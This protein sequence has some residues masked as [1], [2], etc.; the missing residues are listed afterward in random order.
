MAGPA[1]RLGPGNGENGGGHVVDNGEGLCE[2]YGRSISGSDLVLGEHRPTP[3]PALGCQACPIDIHLASRRRRRA[4]NAR[5]EIVCPVRSEQGERVVRRQVDGDAGGRL[6][7]V[8]DGPFRSPVW[9]V[10]IFHVHSGLVSHRPGNT[11]HNEGEPAFQLFVPA[12]VEAVGIEMDY[13][14]I[15]QWARVC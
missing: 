12:W 7:P 13:V 6:D 2:V 1:C 10:A 14:D 8:G 3:P 15:S 9:T 5:Q 4:D 11:R